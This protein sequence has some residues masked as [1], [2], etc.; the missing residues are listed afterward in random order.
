MTTM[1]QAIFYILRIQVKS[2]C[3]PLWSLNSSTPDTAHHAPFFPIGFNL[4]EHCEIYFFNCHYFF[5]WVN[6]PLKTCFYV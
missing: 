1:C 6:V 2:K 4:L 5:T 3:I